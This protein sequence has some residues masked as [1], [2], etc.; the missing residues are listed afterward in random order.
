MSRKIS[1]LSHFSVYVNGIRVGHG[2]RTDYWTVAPG[3]VDMP[4]L[5]DQVTKLVITNDEFKLIYP[6]GSTVIVDNVKIF[7]S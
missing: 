3:A 6:I 1:T 4:N 5:I 2:T 7:G